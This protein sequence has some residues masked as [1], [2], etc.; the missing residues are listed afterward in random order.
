MV[1]TE[2]LQRLR[3]ARPAAAEGRPGEKNV[4]PI[5]RCIKKAKRK[6]AK[7]KKNKKRLIRIEKNA[8]PIQRCIPPS[9]HCLY[10]ETTISKVVHTSVV[11]CVHNYVNDHGG[12]G[13]GSDCD[14]NDSDS[15]GQVLLREG[16]A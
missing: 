11:T 7:R 15:D 8:S 10:F 9:L 14:E 6:K 1:M 4:S 2:S 16:T 3:G 5:Q 12:G 13:E